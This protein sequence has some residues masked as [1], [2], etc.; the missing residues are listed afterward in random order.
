MPMSDN[1]LDT[2]K[3]LLKDSRKLSEQFA[4]FKTSSQQSLEKFTE[5][6]Q[7]LNNAI[8]DLEERIEKLEESQSS[9]GT[10]AV[11]N[12]SQSFSPEEIEHLLDLPLEKILDVYSEVPQLLEI[13]CRRVAVSINDNSSNPVLER[14]NQGNYWVLQLR[15][16]GFF[17]LPRF[18]AFVRIT[19]LESLQR[20]FE[21]EG[22]IPDSGNYEFLLKRPAKLEL[23]KRNQ[24][25]QLTEKGLIQFGESPLEFRWQQE[26]R[27]MRD[28][29]QEFTKMLEKVGQAG[30][31]AT[32]T[33][34][35]W[36]QELEQRY[37]EPVSIMINT[38][39]PMAYVIYK[40]PMFVP[41]HV[42][43]VRGIC[44]VQPAWDRGVPWETTIYAKSHSRNVLRSS[45][46]H[47][48]LANQPYF[49]EITYLKEQKNQT[50][51]I[52]NTYEEASRIISLLNGNW[53]SLEDIPS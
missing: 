17:L 32:V 42:V 22:K 19:A 16:Q 12:F 13:I 15:E 8:A 1:T 53:G 33:T 34:Q 5:F 43:L 10:V 26:I 3:F 25:W 28:R 9:V 50:W 37:G 44:L 39:M 23:L 20:L 40:G 46:D 35:L 6:K 49:K 47:P 29:Y 31:E 41:C 48:I 36:Q 38:C 14:N 30:L 18:G 51:A 45:P 24:R 27:Q 52:A 21:S 7:Q 2:L 4:E 11:G